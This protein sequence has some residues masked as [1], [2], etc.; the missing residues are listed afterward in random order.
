MTTLTM[1]GNIRE[2]LLGSFE[3]NFCSYIKR[4][5]LQEET[6]ISLPLLLRM[7]VVWFW[8]LQ[9]LQPSWDY[10]WKATESMEMLTKW[11]VILQLLYPTCNHLLPD[12]LPLLF[13]P[14]S[15]RNSFNRI[16]NPSQP[17]RLMLQKMHS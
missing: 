6:V 1:Q 15:I 3:G 8:C 5:A 12:F 11:S 9:V 14:Q 17:I 4:W 2:S 13:K 10:N 16:Q 7:L